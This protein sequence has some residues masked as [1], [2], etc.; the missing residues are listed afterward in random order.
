VLALTTADV[1]A[2]ARRYY[3]SSRAA[4]VVAGRW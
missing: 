3:D 2:A 4:I 1:S